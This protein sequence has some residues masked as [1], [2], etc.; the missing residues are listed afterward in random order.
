[1]REK[2]FKKMSKMVDHNEVM[3]SK[4]GNIST[5]DEVIAVT[6]AQTGIDYDYERN[7]MPCVMG[8]SVMPGFKLKNLM[9]QEEIVA[10][11]KTLINGYV[12]NTFSTLVAQMQIYT[13]EECC[14]CFSEK[15][16]VVFYRCG[17]SCTDKVC[18]SQ[19]NKCPLCR[20]TVSAFVPLKLDSD[21]E[22]TSKQPNNTN[23]VVEPVCSC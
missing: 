18:G 12:T 20:M 7:S 17:H 9:S 1:L 13:S 23:R 16:D 2:S 15:P 4:V 6:S 19:L 5:G 11:I 3:Q 10:E 8:V 14:V 22:Q 21:S